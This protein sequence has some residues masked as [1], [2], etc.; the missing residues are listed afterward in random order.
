MVSHFRPSEVLSHASH[1]RLV[2]DDIILKSRLAI[3][4][5]GSSAIRFASICKLITKITILRIL[6]NLYIYWIIILVS[7]VYKLKS[8]INVMFYV[9]GWYQ[10]FVFSF[11]IH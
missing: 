2:S 6:P 9:Y 4:L 7:H 11:L 3:Y 10:R 1:F 5:T 8:Y